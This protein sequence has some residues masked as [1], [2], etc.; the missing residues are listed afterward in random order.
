MQRRDFLHAGALLAAG[1][2]AA[3]AATAKV[4]AADP[5]PN[6][7]PLRVGLVGCGWYGKTD[8]FHL[9]QVAPVEVVGLCDV[10]SAAREAAGA[11]VAKRQPSGKAPPLFG[12]YRTLLSEAKPEIVLVAT[13]DHWHCLPMI[14]ACAAGADVYVQKPISFDVVEGRAM[15]AAARKHGRT[16]QVGLQRR[17]TPHLL[18]ARDRFVTTGRLGKVAAVDIHS[19]YGTRDAFPPAAPAPAT[20]DWDMY[21]GPAPL[22][23]YNPQIHPRSWRDC[24]EF[25]N[26]QTGDLCVHFFDTVRY[27]L[28][29]SWPERISASGGVL[30]RDPASNVKLHDTQTALFDH[31]PVQITWTQR[32]WGENPDPD[33]PWGATLYGS[34]GT[35]RLSVTRWD[36]KPRDGGPAEHGEFLDEREK[37]PE[38]VAHKETEAFAAPA[39]R[40]HMKNFLAARTSG[41]KPVADIAEGHVSSAVCIMANLAM[42][43][44]RSLSLDADGHVIDDDEANALLTRPYRAPWKHPTPESV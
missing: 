32:N 12:D 20:L 43:L 29:L 13:P 19:Y 25:S 6:T 40:A 39:T 8:L 36:Y 34:K 31:G 30:V 35:L 2:T 11:L 28:G 42:R 24:I 33:Y 5:A 3:V 14:E 9:M 15:V 37:Y 44:G 4:R 7:K 10:D 23:P 1:S 38:D 41:E 16:V 27:F 22:V 17:S 18:D 21:C 26:G